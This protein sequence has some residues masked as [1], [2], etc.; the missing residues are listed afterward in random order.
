Y[1]ITVKRPDAGEIP[2]R[3]FDAR[4]YTALQRVQDVSDARFDEVEFGGFRTR[5]L[6]CHSC[7]ALHS[8]RSYPEISFSLVGVRVKFR[9]G[10]EEQG[11]RVM[12]N[13]ARERI[14]GAC[15]RSIA[16]SGLRG[17]RMQDVA[18]EA[19]VSIGL[20]AY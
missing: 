9:T 20:L 5:L 1:T 3:Q 17:F 7:L 19:G 8:A 4:D 15:A 14:L 12:A 13:D 6:T 16:R 18:R 10:Q 11:G 2:C